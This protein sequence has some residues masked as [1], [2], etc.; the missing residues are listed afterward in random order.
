MP[1]AE[2]HNF[3]AVCFLAR[4]D[5]P[6]ATASGFTFEVLREHVRAFDRLGQVSAAEKKA[7][8]PFFDDGSSNNG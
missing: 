5:I 3:L 4:K 7:L 1:L 2:N 8:A 6:Y